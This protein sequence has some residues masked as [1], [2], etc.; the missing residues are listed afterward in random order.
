LTH[1]VEPRATLL[2]ILGEGG[3]PEEGSEAYGKVL[4][5]EPAADGRVVITLALTAMAPNVR[6]ELEGRMAVHF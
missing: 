5:L 4:A 6:R 2:V 1:S 3:G